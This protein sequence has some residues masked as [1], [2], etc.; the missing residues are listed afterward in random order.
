MV[1][2]LTAADISNP[3]VRGVSSG[4]RIGLG[5]VMSAP[6]WLICKPC[7]CTSAMPSEDCAG[8]TDLVHHYQLVEDQVLGFRS[9]QWNHL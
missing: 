3:E 5:L 2:C 7:I 4:F 1:W 6:M 9:C 8:E